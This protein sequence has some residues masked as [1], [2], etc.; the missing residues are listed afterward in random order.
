[1]RAHDV[2]RESASRRSLLVAWFGRMRFAPMTLHCGALVALALLA[3]CAKETL[4]QSNFD[5]TP[6]NDPPATTQQV[7]TGAIDGGAGQVIVVP[8]PSLP[9]KWVQ[10]SRPNADT[11][12]AGFQG[13]F[14][15]SRGDGEYTFTTTVFMPTGSGVATIQCERFGQAANDV[16]SF[17]HVDL[18]PENNV[19]ID[20][21]ENTR[22]GTF[23]RDQPFI[24][25]L[26]LNI[27]A[28]SPSAQ[29][30]LSGA[31][32]SGNAVRNISPAFIPI[33]RQF[34]AIRVWMGFPHTGSFNAT[35][36]VVS[37]EKS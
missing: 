27:N 13:N 19:R 2:F 8:L 34:G 10:I 12:V 32:A 25:Q 23:P 16:S 14:V 35:N 24:V 21:D 9:G 29:V 5:A 3:G 33:A 20:D 37:R 15:A 18:M 31:D 36:I 28:S 1:M 6:D 26:T 4:F 17:L 7:G 11:G 30:V 22:F